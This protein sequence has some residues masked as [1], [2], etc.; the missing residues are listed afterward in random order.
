MLLGGAALQGEALAWAGRIAAKTGC[1]LLAENLNARME[2]GAGRVRVERLAY[3]V[4]MALAQLATVER[5]V[6]CGARAPGSGFP[7][8]EGRQRRDDDGAD[9]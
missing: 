1:R 2:R 6:L 4:K 3:P 9:H 7:Q 8:S 5:L